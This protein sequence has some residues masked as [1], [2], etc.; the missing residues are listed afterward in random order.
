MAKRLFAVGAGVTMLGATAMGALAIGDLSNYP[1]FFVSNGTFNGLVVIGEHAATADNLAAI[2]ITTSMK[3]AGAAA[4]ATTTITGD[5][6]LAGTS[7]KHL[8][9]ANNNATTI[10]GENLY[11][12]EQFIGKESLGAL[13]DGTYVTNAGSSSY[14]QYLYTDKANNNQNEIVAYRTNDKDTTADFFYVKSGAN[15]GE[16]VLEF[17]S[18]PESSLQDTTGAASTSG[19]VID[20]FENSKISMMGK[21][22]NIV[23]ARRPQTRPQGSIKL[24]LMGGAS[25]GTLLEGETSTVSVGAKSYDVALTF[26]DQTYAKFTVNGQ[27]TDKL[28]VGDSYK[29]SDGTEVGVSE[30][31]YQNYAG[32]VHSTD[33]FL[34]AS[35]LVLQDNDVTDTATTSELKASSDTIS[36]ASVI[37]EGTDDNTT[38]RINKIHVNMTAQDDYYVAAGKKLS[39]AIAD[40]GD[41][42]ELL[43]TNNWDIQYAGLS[44][45]TTH[46]IRLHSNTDRKYKLQFYDGNNNMVDLPIAY[47]INI[48]HLQLTEDGAKSVVFNEGINMTKDDYFVIT[49]G[50]AADGT[51][52]TFALQYKGADKTTA[53]SP[54]IR[55]KDIGTGDELEYSVD[56]TSTANAVATIKLGGYSFAV[57]N[58]SSKASNDFSLRIDLDGDGTVEANAEVDIVDY[59]GLQ[60]DFGGAMSFNESRH[61]LAQPT[62]T[63][64]SRIDMV[65]TTPNGNDWDNFGPSAINVSASGTTGTEVTIGSLTLDGASAATI[66]PSGSENVAY[67]YTSMGGKITHT[68]PSG[69]PSGF[70]YEYPENQRYP[71]VYITSGAVSSSTKTAGTTPVSIVDATKMDSEVASVDAQNLLV[72]GGPCVNTVAATLLGN[73]TDCAAGFRAGVARVKLFEQT[74]GNVAM[75]VAGYSGADTRLAGQVIAH[76]A[77]DL[78]GTEVEIE[79]TTYGDATI[80]APRAVVA[81][82]AATTE[83]TTTTGTQ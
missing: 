18:G 61:V 82:P 77:A 80:G 37:I 11:A 66:T 39:D 32:G 58:T 2:D 34:G 23:L 44:A 48:T 79:G 53:T 75:L 14:T 20:D 31:L 54:K 67:G 70:T 65:M 10:R 36:G 29:L 60:I 17:S 57:Q 13:A 22:Y 7:A 51:A 59:Y 50:T 9:M 69:S 73:P 62:A 6:W 21:E 19:A 4:S 12:I 42:K 55:F 52:R 30:I 45:E 46:E 33:F 76:R 3:Y 81:A 49:S 1:N 63:N 27:Q 15:I 24:T 64:Q 16:Y 56:T 26:V 28:Q 40:R 78:S 41:E 5:K 72:V 68:T 8:E 47:A 35:K 71:Q 43:F 83:T 38:F 25:S 74:N